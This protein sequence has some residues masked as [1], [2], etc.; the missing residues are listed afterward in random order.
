MYKYYSYYMILHKLATNALVLVV[1]I[2]SYREVLTS[3]FF[4]SS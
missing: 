3:C 1:N 2:A 4:V